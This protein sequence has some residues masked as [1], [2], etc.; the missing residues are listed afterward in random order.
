MIKTTLTS[1]EKQ[2]YEKMPIPFCILQSRMGCVFLLAVSDGFCRVMHMDCRE[3]QDD[4]KTV[5]MKPLHP[6]GYKHIEENFDSVRLNP[7]A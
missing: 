6:V 3:F 4:V 7:V 5:R 1:A 2:L